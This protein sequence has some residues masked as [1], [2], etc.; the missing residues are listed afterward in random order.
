MRRDPAFSATLPPQDG[1]Q[2]HPGC[3]RTVQRISAATAALIGAPG[4]AMAGTTF[5]PPAG[6]SEYRLLF[7]TADQT[8]ASSTD[9][10]TYNGF[11]TSEATQNPALPT[12]T[13]TAIAST[14]SVNAV[15]NVDCGASCDANVPIYLVD[16]TTL[17]ATSTAAFFGATILN[18]PSED[19][20]G[21]PS[22]AYAWTGSN[23]DGTATTTYEMGG[24]QGTQV[25][26]TQSTGTTVLSSFFDAFNGVHRSPSDQY[27]LYALSGA[28]EVTVPEPATGSALLVGGLIITRVFR[29]R[30]TH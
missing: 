21:N 28:I 6:V 7:V 18:A 11:V 5:T 17:V 10:S 27:S 30:R 14:T 19:Q 22:Y 15:T 29:R 25:G 13:W 3:G 23:S 1:G 4:L 12:T 24:S 2:W 8:A 20:S 9:I 16:G 26:E